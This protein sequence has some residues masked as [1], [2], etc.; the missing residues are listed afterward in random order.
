M[1]RSR[2][3][4]ADMLALRGQRRLSMIHIESLEAAGDCFV[5]VGLQYGRLCTYDDYIRAAHDAILGGG[6][7]V[8]CA[9][10]L[11]NMSRLA[12]EGI[13]VCGHTGLIPSKRTWTGGFRTRRCRDA[14]AH[15]C[16]PCARAHPRHCR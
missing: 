3:T 15:I 2:K 7:A 8:Y 10:R 4:V 6:D 1:N 5:F 11:E 9:A 14:Q 13:P 12:S 16:V